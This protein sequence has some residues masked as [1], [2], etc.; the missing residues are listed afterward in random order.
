MFLSNK[1]QYSYKSGFQKPYLKAKNITIAF[2]NTSMPL[3]VSIKFETTVV[4]TRKQKHQLVANQ[5]MAVS[6]TTSF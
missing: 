3:G 1:C 5:T 6:K 2:D 4:S